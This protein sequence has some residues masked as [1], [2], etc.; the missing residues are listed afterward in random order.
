LSFNPGAILK[1]LMAVQPLS[2][3]RPE[4]EGG[5]TLRRVLGWPALI[6]IG[7]GTMLG[8]IFTTM[9]PG[10]QAAGPGVILAFI[11]SGAACVFVALCYA[12]FA[13]MVPVAGSAYT[14]AYATLGEFIAWIIGWDL[15][16]E[17]GISAAPVAS[18]FSG[19]VQ[20]YLQSF[21]I[22]LPAWSQSAQLA[23]AWAP[24]SIGSWHFHTL[25]VDL[26][27]SHYDVIAAVI[28]LLISVLLAI[29]IRESAGANA[30]FVWVQVAAF[31]I[32][33]I[34][35]F[36]A[37]HPAN[38]TPFAP[39]GL[40]AI[41][42]SAALVFFA[43]I[44]F[45][46]VT[47]AS[48]ES[49]NPQR[50][51]PIGVIGSLVIGG[52]LY[53]LIA[54]FTVGVVPW[55]HV[56]TNSA[57]GQAVRLA[58]SNRFF[59]AAVTAGAIAGTTSVMVTSLLGQTRIFYVMARDRMLPPVFAAVHPRFR[60]P[61]RMT[62]ITG[63]LVSILALIVPLEKLLELVNIGTLSA[64]VIVSI[65]VF[66]LRFVAPH[67]HRPFKAPFG[68]AMSV[69]GCVSC[70]WMMAALPAATWIRFVVWFAVG[71]VIYAIYGYRHSLL[72]VQQAD[73]PEPSV[74]D[75]TVR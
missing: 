72:R 47:V 53:I 11:L 26:L 64:F 69:L 32:F 63:V 29:G 21:K 40:H 43:Y 15:I 48:E 28:V 54:V 49:R 14:Y 4:E 51:V 71:V 12:E 8:G 19:Y 27:A 50:D 10:T 74:I 57:M 73:A 3:V 5:P 9:G 70:L 23:T 13:S 17:Y 45:D 37:I 61:A 36:S 58:S 34:A 22:T 30:I 2:R 59:I 6:G 46:T 31:I 35:C 25:H 65:G 38:F 66:V 42:R 44:G 56:D 41:V 7:L 20:E 18:S 68:L 62:M 75:P 55:Q 24:A 52:I 67:A 1:R 60:T 39:N 33:F 16:L